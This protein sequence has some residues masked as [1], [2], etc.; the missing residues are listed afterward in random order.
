MSWT[1]THVYSVFSPGR[2][3]VM[4][5][6]SMKMHFPTSSFPCIFACV[7]VLVQLIGCVELGLAARGPANDGNS[8]VSPRRL[9]QELSSPSRRQSSPPSE[10][11]ESPYEGYG[12]LRAYWRRGRYGRFSGEFS[13]GGCMTDA[14]TW[15]WTENGGE[16]AFVKAVDLGV[17]TS[18]PNLS[19]CSLGPGSS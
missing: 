18:I 12:T 14:G 13:R 10:D 4:R 8:F 15:T 3:D 5:S 17:G 1:S 19:S 16:C 11:E 7:L 6:P 9:N 2:Q